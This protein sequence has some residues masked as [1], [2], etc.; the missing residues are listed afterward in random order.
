MAR[1]SFLELKSGD[2]GIL[3]KAGPFNL[4]GTWGGVMGDVINKKFD[5]S[6]S[7]WTW[8]L[9]RYTLVQFVPFMKGVHTLVWTPKIPETDFGLFTRY[10]NS[11]DALTQKVFAMVIQ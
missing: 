1:A 7:S 11:I 3:P 5:F 9:A 8:N 6:L 10:V 4:S 2:W